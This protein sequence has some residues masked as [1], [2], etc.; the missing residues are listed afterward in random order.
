MKPQEILPSQKNTLPGVSLAS[1]LFSRGWLQDYFA[2]ILSFIILLSIVIFD[3]LVLGLDYLYDPQPNLSTIG[4]VQLAVI[5][6]SAVL[7]VVPIARKHSVAVII[8]QKNSQQIEQNLTFS[9]GRLGNL[10]L[11]P[12]L[13]VWGALLFSVSLVFL[14]VLSP[15]LFFRLSVEDHLIEMLSV[16]FLFLACGYFCLLATQTRHIN[17][18]PKMFYL[19][20]LVLLALAL[21]FIGMEEISWF[22]RSFSIVTPDLFRENQQQEMNLHNFATNEI[23]ILYYFFSFL[24]FILLPFI[25]DRTLLFSR[26]S[27]VSFFIPG[28][29]ILFISAPFAAFNYNL[30]NI[31]TTQFSFFVTL[32][33]LLHYTYL[34]FRGQLNQPFG[35]YYLTVLFIVYV[36][37]QLIFL[38]RGDTFIRTWDVTE[39]K[40]LLVPF[41]F[42][43]Y[44]LTI[45]MK[46]RQVISLR[47]VLLTCV[48]TLLL[49]FLRI[50]PKVS[51]YF[52]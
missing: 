21:F 27:Q 6:L 44:S 2:P 33:I 8:Q 14:F 12:L 23:E 36:V 18:K 9:F 15:G 26:L 1:A 38:I 22:Q 50:L 49:I 41:S 37:T 51:V 11:S 24:F 17:V 34:S 35:K 4:L 20:A 10:S 47:F 43:V 52:L 13:L 39:Y 25:N 19:A 29:L 28:L 42:F 31:P 40:E 46:S 7:L 45:I 3:Y 30:W 32:L 5:F 48:I 16:L